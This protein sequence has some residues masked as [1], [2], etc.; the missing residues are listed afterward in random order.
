MR[1]VLP[2]IVMLLCFT[3]YPVYLL[4]YCGNYQKEQREEIVN[5]YSE[6]TKIASKYS[7]KKLSYDFTTK[8]GR[9]IFSDNENNKYAFVISNKKVIKEDKLDYQTYIR[10][11]NEAVNSDSGTHYRVIMAGRVPVVVSD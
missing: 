8:N 1:T 10:Y 5:F 7:N 2:T 4:F 6:I 9:Y 11:K 3:A